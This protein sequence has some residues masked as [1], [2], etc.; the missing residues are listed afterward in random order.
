MTTMAEVYGLG[1]AGDRVWLEGSRDAE[2]PVRD[3][4]RDHLDGDQ[5]LLDRCQ[6]PTLDVGCGPGRLSTA[7]LGRGVPTLGI[8]ISRQAVALARLRGD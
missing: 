5:A 2:L 7:L 4:N 6:G 8:D 3:W 1:L